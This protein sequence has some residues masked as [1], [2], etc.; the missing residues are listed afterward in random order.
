MNSVRV[1]FTGLLSLLFIVIALYPC[2][3]IYV[4]ADSSAHTTL[5]YQ[6]HEQQHA[7]VDDCSPL[8]A[9]VCCAASVTVALA[10]QV[11]KIHSYDTPVSTPLPFNNI[12]QGGEKTI[13]Q[14]PKIA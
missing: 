6:S 11:T 2:T 13:W 5:V 10:I 1:L 14:P 9:C 3:D 7:A 4:Q 8:C 12:I